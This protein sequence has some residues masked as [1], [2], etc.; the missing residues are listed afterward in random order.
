LG[1]YKVAVGTKLVCPGFIFGL[2]ECGHHDNFGV[3]GFRGIAQDVQHV[4]T[5]NPRHHYIGNDELWFFFDG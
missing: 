4:K 2:G 1:F 5:A 3:L